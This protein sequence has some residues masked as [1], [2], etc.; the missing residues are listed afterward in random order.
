ML[1]AGPADVLD[2]KNYILD[3]DTIPFP[4]DHIC[5]LS[6]IEVMTKEFEGLVKEK[7]RLDPTQAVSKLYNNIRYKSTYIYIYITYINFLHSK[8]IL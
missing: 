5:V 3:V 1:S 6:G 7:L 8:K 2:E 4:Y